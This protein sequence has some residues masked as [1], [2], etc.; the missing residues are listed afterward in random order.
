MAVARTQEAAMADD[1]TPAPEPAPEPQVE[2]EPAPAPAD[3]LGDAGKRALDAERK[4]RADAEKQA[5]ALEKRLAEIEAQNMTD[6]ERAIAE[7]RAEGA[8]EAQTKIADRLV[9]A[10]IRIA[11]AGKVAPE[12]INDLPALMGELAQFADEAGEI[13]TDRITAAIAD[14]VASRPFL[15]PVADAKPAPDPD[16]GAVSGGGAQLTV[17][18][19]RSMSP[20]EAYAAYREGRAAAAM[21]S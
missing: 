20:E 19:L 21:G 3:D 18:Q 1:P 4:A 16:Q 14:L 13:D 8:R 11:A 2:P 9:R 6:T 12:A 10:E 17:E 7:A 5:K 15:A